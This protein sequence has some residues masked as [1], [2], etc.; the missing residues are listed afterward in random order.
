M[1]KGLFAAYLIG[2]RFFLLIKKEI[3]CLVFFFQAL[4]IGLAV[5]YSKECAVGPAYW[6]K[7]FENAQ[8]CGALGHC[9]DTV[10]INDNRFA[11]DPSRAC[12]WCQKILKNTHKGLGD[13]EVRYFSIEKILL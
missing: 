2:R 7:S 11:V 5:S 9:T 4:S 10:W 1:A 13:N 3:K 8:D 12:Q 6:C